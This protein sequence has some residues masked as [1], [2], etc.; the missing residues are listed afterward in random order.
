VVLHVTEG[1]LG[2]FKVVFSGY[3]DLLVIMFVAF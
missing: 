3:E 2:Y 1:F